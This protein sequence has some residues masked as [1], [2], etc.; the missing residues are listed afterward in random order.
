MA[1]PKNRT[2][3]P[4]ISAG[5]TEQ[6]DGSRSPGG[7]KPI[8]TSFRKFPDG[9]M[10]ELVRG[11]ECAE[12]LQLLV[13]RRGKA[14][15]C[16]SF[17]KDS[18]LLVPPR[19]TPGLAGAIQF[20]SAISTYKDLVDVVTDIVVAARA[21]VRFS[22]QEDAYLVAAYVLSTWLVDRFAHAPYL[23]VIGTLGSG[24]T[25]L[26]RFLSCCCRRPLLL[27]DISAAGLYSLTD[28]LQPT[29]LLDEAAF[30]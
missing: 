30:G 7:P 10:V 22:N 19:V 2:R 28:Q 20:P 11:A 3:Q 15:I 6:I 26:L 21:H 5:A 1:S 16:S 18:E 27:A 13:W 12:E 14:R 29:L 24:K 23:S 17:L 4:K 8:E 9:T 25:Q